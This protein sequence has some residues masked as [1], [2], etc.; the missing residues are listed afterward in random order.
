MQSFGG[1]PKARGYEGVTV[2]LVRPKPYRFPFWHALLVLHCIVSNACVLFWYIRATWFKD[3]LPLLPCV[4]I[5][6]KWL[7]KDDKQI[8]KCNQLSDACVVRVVRKF[9]RHGP[10]ILWQ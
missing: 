4:L 3:A 7:R 1:G 2:L 5:S 6:T 10:D 9:V 8:E